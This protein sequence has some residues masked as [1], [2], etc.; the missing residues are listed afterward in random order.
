MTSPAAEG[1]VISTVTSPDAPGATVIPMAV[2]TPPMA[3]PET[4]VTLYVGVQ[5]QEPVFC[6]FQVFLIACPGVTT[7]LSGYVTS[8]TKTELLHPTAPDAPPDVD[9]LEVVG[10]EG[11]VNKVGLAVGSAR[12]VAVAVGVPAAVA[13]GEASN[14]ACC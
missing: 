4:N 5:A 1:A 11:F 7:V 13:V 10:I 9:P 8:D 12:K 14:N 6:N 3:L 2:A